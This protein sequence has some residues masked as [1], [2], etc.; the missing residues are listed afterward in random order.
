MI[1]SPCEEGEQDMAVTPGPNRRVTNRLQIA[2]RDAKGMQMRN[3]KDHLSCVKPGQV[4]VENALSVQLEEEM[5]P[6][7]KVQHQVEL[8]RRLHEDAQQSHVSLYT[9]MTY[10]L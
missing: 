10:M 3:S 5:P 4:L 9:A 8:A 1:G 6:V 2:V 7:D